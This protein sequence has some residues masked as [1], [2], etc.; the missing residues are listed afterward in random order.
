MLGS[1][2]EQRARPDALIATN[3]SAIP[4]GSLS[5]SPRVV[6]LHFFNPVHAMP[7]VEV[8]RPRRA[9]SES[10]SNAVRFVQ[11][12]GKLPLVVADTPGFLV[13]RVLMPYL[14][15]AARLVQDG[16]GARLIVQTSRAAATQQ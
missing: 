15:E 10:V 12:I 2:L 8:V 5:E 7:L 1:D 3:T 11:D 13:N 14:L 16:V 6:G 4:V 9:A